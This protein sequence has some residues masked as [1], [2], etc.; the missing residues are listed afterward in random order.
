MTY[1]EYELEEQA[2]LQAE[3]NA[4]AIAEADFIEQQR[5]EYEN[6]TD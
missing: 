6:T 2:Q 4:Q 1:Q 3:Y 5:E